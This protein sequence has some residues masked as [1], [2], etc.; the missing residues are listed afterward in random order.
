VA[1]AALEWLARRASG[2]VPGAIS[3]AIAAVGAWWAWV[4]EPAIRAQP[5]VLARLERMGASVHF[6][7]LVTGLAA[8]VGLVL[9]AWAWLRPGKSIGD[10]WQL[11]LDL[12]AH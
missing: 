5:D 10:L 7:L 3:L 4:C 1:L 8:L 9:L 6:P 2:F 11:L 12:L